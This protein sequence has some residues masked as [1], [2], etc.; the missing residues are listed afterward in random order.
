MMWQF[1]VPKSDLNKYEQMNSFH[2]LQ[3]IVNKTKLSILS[4]KI[5]QGTK[6]KVQGINLQLI[7]LF[8]LINQM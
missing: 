4:L 1:L 7:C 5:A 2:R 6:L 8:F 3:L